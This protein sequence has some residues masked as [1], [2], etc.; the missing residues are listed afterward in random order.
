V[1]PSSI[2]PLFRPWFA[3]PPA[4]AYLLSGEGTGLAD[5]LGELW[6]SRFRAEGT[7]SE[8]IRWTAADMERESLEAVWRT[9]S[10][11]CRYRVFVLPDLGDLKKGPREALLGYLRTPDPAVIL[12]LPCS[13]RAVSKAFS[14]LPGVRSLAPREEQ[15]VS[16]LARTAV[17]TAGESGTALSEDAATFLVR[18]V[19]ADFVRVMEEVK[20]LIAFS[21]G[22]PEI[23]EEE[24]RKVCIA[25]GAVDP[26]A[27]AEKLV[28]RDGKVCLSMFRQF[29]SRAEASDYHG[30][31]GAVAWFVRKRLSD[32]GAALTPRRGGEILKA[33]SAIDRGMKGESGLSPEQ[34]FEIHL[35]KL[36]S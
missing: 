30:L 10:F 17:T 21:A 22:R 20:K 32:K 7:T 6:V 25:E 31:V 33:L 34:L 13:E 15:V 18:W 16:T 4:S 23:G 2:P 29:A 36:L 24:I 28:R 1:N 12:V 19:G 14:T 3:G 27:L 11:F 8:L 26:F 5:F 35:L 9:P